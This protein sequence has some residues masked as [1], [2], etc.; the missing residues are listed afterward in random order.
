M[1]S[2]RRLG[3][4]LLGAGA[5][6]AARPLVGRLFAQDQTPNRPELTVVAR[7]F[8]FA[9]DRI[10]V[11]QDDLVKL[12]IRSEDVAYSFAIDEYR[13]VRRIPPGATTTL[14]FRADRPGSFR[15][16]SNLTSEPRHGEMQ[17]E[18]VVRAK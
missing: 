17:G 6:L 4:L 14:E 9:P 11:T 10:E 12:T 3:L 5:L 2:R 15:F 16:Y 18:L 8:R 7:D 13:I 1:V